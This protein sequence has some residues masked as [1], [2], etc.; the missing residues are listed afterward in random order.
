[1]TIR[2]H[3]RQTFFTTERR[4]P[5]PVT[6]GNI[7]WQHEQGSGTFAAALNAFSNSSGLRTRLQ[8][9]F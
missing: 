5:L 7:R 8:L 3:C 9:H 6:V 4:D 2:E 1:L